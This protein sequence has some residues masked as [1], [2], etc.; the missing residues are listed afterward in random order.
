MG[1]QTYTGRRSRR[2]QLAT[3]AVILIGIVPPVWLGARQFSRRL[4]APTY[5]R[6]EAWLATNTAPDDRILSEH[7]WLWLEEVPARVTRVWNLPEVLAGGD[8]QLYEHDWVV[9]PE[10]YYG[11]SGLDRLTLA[12]EFRSDQ[13]FGGTR[14]IS[15]RIYTPKPVALVPAVDVDPGAESADRFLGA[16]WMREASNLPGIAVPRDGGNLYVPT[17]QQP[18]A[19]VEVEVITGGALPA[20]SGPVLHMRV[21]GQD[22]AVATA[23]LSGHQLRVVSDP[24]PSELYGDR[25]TVI[26]LTPTD[27]AG[28]DVRMLRFSI[29]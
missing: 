26:R 9:V 10:P 16:G 23:R 29:R 20:A 17:P 8:Y 18:G 19:R 4:V 14:G 5:A 15:F 1:G 28:G 22:V 12:R 2:A 6:A 21:G 3:V 24:L 27:A 7:R 13:G 25:I 11:V